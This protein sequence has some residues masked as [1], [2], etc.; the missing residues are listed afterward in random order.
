[1]RPEG[2]PFKATLRLRLIQACMKS[3]ESLPTARFGLD[4]Q[5]GNG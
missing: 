3:L 5:K 1:L 2:K 4:R